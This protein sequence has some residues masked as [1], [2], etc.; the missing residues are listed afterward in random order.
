[1]FVWDC[2]TNV[3]LLMDHHFRVNI[4]YFD[5]VPPVLGDATSGIIASRTTT[6]RCGFRC[7]RGDSVAGEEALASPKKTSSKHIEITNN[8]PHL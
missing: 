1:M 2:V 8:V 4:A 7:D 3:C 6:T 5:G